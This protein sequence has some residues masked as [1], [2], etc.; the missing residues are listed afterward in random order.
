MTT[1][2]DSDSG[3]FAL[4]CHAACPNQTASDVVWNIHLLSNRHDISLLCHDN[5]CTSDNKHTR[6][7][8]LDQEFTTDS[9]NTLHFQF[10]HIYEKAFMGCV[11]NTGDCLSTS[12]WLVNGGEFCSG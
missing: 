9:N 12:Y 11:V 4:G 6:L 10:S 1:P 8:R 7:L 2:K 3:R 5:N